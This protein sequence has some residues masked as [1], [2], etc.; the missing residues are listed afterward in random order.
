MALGPLSGGALLDRGYIVEWAML[1]AG[2][3]ALGL[4]FTLVW[5]GKP[6]T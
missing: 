5:S 2:V 4:L 1:P 6:A 3:S